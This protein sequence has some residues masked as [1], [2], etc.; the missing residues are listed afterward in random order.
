MR[1]LNIVKPVLVAPSMSG[2]SASTSARQAARGAGELSLQY[3][4]LPS[5]SRRASSVAGSYALP[6]VMAGTQSLGGF[7]PVAPVGV[8]D[9]DVAAYEKVGVWSCATRRVCVG[10]AAFLLAAAARV[11]PAFASHPFRPGVACAPFPRPALFVSPPSSCHFRPWLFTAARTREACSAPR[12]WR[13]FQAAKPTS[14]SKRVTGSRSGPTSSAPFLLP[15]AVAQRGILTH[16]AAASLP[17]GTRAIPAT[18]TTPTSSKRCSSTFSSGS[19]IKRRKHCVS[20]ASV[21]MRR[22]RGGRWRA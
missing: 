15:R 5:S 10:V 6:L 17:T 19:P 8:A 4:S 18:S 22:R 12:R 9:F 3:A 1:H 7:V 21:F 13:S 14:S 11:T 20:I 2:A 16:L